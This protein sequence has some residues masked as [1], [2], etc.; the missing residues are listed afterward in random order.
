MR[1]YSLFACIFFTSCQSAPPSSKVILPAFYAWKTTFDPS[2]PEQQ[3]LQQWHTS[4]MYIKYADIDWREGKGAVPVSATD[5]H[6]DH[7]PDTIAVVPVFFIVNQVFAKCPDAETDALA[8]RILQ[9]IQN[10]T[11]AGRDIP[12]IQIDCDWT[13]TTRAAYFHF[14]RQINL[15]ITRIY[16]NR[17]VD[18]SATIRLH[19]VKYRTKTGVPPVDRGLLML[20]NFDNPAKATVKNSII[21]VKTARDYLGNVQAPY[22]LPLDAALPLFHW[23]LHF[24]GRD[25]Q[26]FL[27]DMD[28]GTARESS[29]L[30]RAE[31]NVFT[32]NTDTSCLDTYFRRGDWIRLEDAPSDVLASVWDMAKPLLSNDTCHLVFFDLNL[33]NLQHYKH[34]NLVKLLQN[35]H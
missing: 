19:Q 34:E 23:G 16:G 20:Y 35:N 21:D 1:L 26:G 12:E 6:W 30:T 14:L 4:R 3:I 18:L 17:T 8:R 24:R 10:Q 13:A 32:V 2:E 33:Q 31:K 25:F 11:P 27:H 15:E 5:L 22:P 29:F 9:Y 7:L 28:I